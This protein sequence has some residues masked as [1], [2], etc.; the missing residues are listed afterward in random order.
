[1]KKFR[2]PRREFDRGPGPAEDSWRVEK[3]GVRTCSYDGSLH[4][5]DFMRFIKEGNEVSPT[6]KSYKFYLDKATP[7]VKGAGKFYTHHFSLDLSLG[8]EFISLWEKDEIK[9]GYP[10]H[11]YVK[12]YVP[13]ASTD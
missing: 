10:G 4:P 11:P 8:E 6:D 9:W 1:M 13:R 7:L 3:E 5:E 12:I 2:C